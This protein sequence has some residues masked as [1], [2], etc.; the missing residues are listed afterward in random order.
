MYW[1]NSNQSLTQSISS[2]HKK[3]SDVVE[4]VSY[5]DEYIISKN[6]E[7]AEKIF[8]YFNRP[9]CPKINA[10]PKEPLRFK[11][12]FNP[13]RFMDKP[14]AKMT[15]KFINDFEP[16]YLFFSNLTPIDK[17]PYLI[18]RTEM[19][20]NFEVTKQDFVTSYGADFHNFDFTGNEI[21]FLYAKLYTSSKHDDVGQLFPEF[22]EHGV[23]DFNSD[24]FTER[25]EIFKMMVF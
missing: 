12:N 14:N 10:V 15:I 17:P 18:S 9:S 22:F 7:A 3:N 20:A 13:L 8:K 11:V 19:N 5:V 1:D 24:S 6:N 4:S 21:L 2:Y 25:L 23:Y 16:T